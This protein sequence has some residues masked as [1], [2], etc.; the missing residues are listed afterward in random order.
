MADVDIINEETTVEI[1][2]DDTAVSVT[3]ETTDITVVD[4]TTEV[5]VTVD[6]TEATVIEVAEQGPQGPQ[7]DP[8][9]PASTVTDETSFGGSPVVGV[10]ENYAR[11][12][13]GHGTPASPTPAAGIDTTAIHDN[14]AAE[15][16]AIAE[17]TTLHDDD[18]FIIED[19]EASNAKKKV[20]KS[21]VG[22]SLPLTTKGDLLGFSTLA[23]RVGIGAN[24]KIIRADSSKAHGWD[25]TDFLDNG[26]TLPSN[27]TAG[28]LYLY[29]SIGDLLF[30][31]DGTN[32]I[33]H[34]ALSE[35]NI[36]V[37]AQGGADTV[38]TQNR[39]TSAV[40]FATILAA[41]DWAQMERRADINIR[42]AKNNGGL[43]SWT[44]D[45]NGTIQV[46]TEDVINQS[47]PPSGATY[48]S[49]IGTMIYDSTDTGVAISS[50]AQGTGD[51]TAPY[52][53]TYATAVRASGN[54]Q[55][56]SAGLFLKYRDDTDTVAL[57]G[58]IRAIKSVS[59]GTATLIGQ[60]LAVPSPGA[61]NDTVDVLYP[62]VQ[63][64]TDSTDYSF[65]NIGGKN[66][67]L[68]NLDFDD[69]VYYEQGAGGGTEACIFRD[70]LM[71]FDNSL[72]NA[73]DSIFDNSGA[74]LGLY[75]QRSSTC[76][77]TRFYVYDVGT[78]GMELFDYCTVIMY[79]NCTFRN[80][81]T[82]IYCENSKIVPRNGQT[83]IKGT[84]SNATYL[85]N[86]H[87]MPG[88]TTGLRAVVNGIVYDDRIHNQAGTPSSTATQGQ[89]L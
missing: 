64:V 51:F 39:G 74:Y 88:T 12:D 24:N 28:D 76:R 79:D 29:T 34:L 23:L 82:A 3:E 1:T 52:T 27:H 80:C 20:R 40:P 56:G 11:E 59:G 86:M 48:V 85:T 14:A 7:G 18:L 32:W 68:Y 2:V 9:T 57:R 63:I 55:A 81:T 71:I 6:D 8:Q 84:Y 54:W 87:I 30:I 35:L 10:S 38:T 69:R 16:S 65:H 4:E 17:K 72:L 15:V 46:Y 19:S 41:L 60:Q 78:D 45:G 5:I 21:N 44:E 66:V 13:H 70:Y 50:G 47:P 33:P 43:D 36:Y 53:P 77:L 31:S 22:S 75:M 61:N 25:W 62:G 58:Q 89:I 26:D 67:L 83:D 49:L 37:G 42:I 73:V